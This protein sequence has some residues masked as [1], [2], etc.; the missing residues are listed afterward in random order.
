FPPIFSIP[1]IL[2]FS[3]VL[4]TCL[5]KIHMVV[6]LP[7]SST[8]D[9]WHYHA[10]NLSRP[11][12]RSIHRHHNLSTFQPRSLTFTKV[13]LNFEELGKLREVES[14]NICEN[15]ADHM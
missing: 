12:R 2:L 1:P 5:Y 10:F 8:P 7:S 14:L 6:S 15:L 9:L 4:Y 11:P 3:L 13:C